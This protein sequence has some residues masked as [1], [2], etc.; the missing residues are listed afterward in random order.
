MGE[1]AEYFGTVWFTTAVRVA[2]AARRRMRVAVGAGL[3]GVVVVVV[4]FGG[5]GSPR[6]GPNTSGDMRDSGFLCIAF[7]TG[8]DEVNGE[9]VTHSP[10]YT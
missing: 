9:H 1:D 5:S 3:T 2:C 7:Y 6:S 10:L 8:H 4:I